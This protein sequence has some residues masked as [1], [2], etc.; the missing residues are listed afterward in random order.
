MGV[1]SAHAEALQYHLNV[2][3]DC[4]GDVREEQGEAERI[5][6]QVGERA[7]STNRD[8][9]ERLGRRIE[10]IQHSPFSFK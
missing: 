2:Q 8:D 3:D 9:H 6:V 1:E 7:C 5:A 4:A 10:R